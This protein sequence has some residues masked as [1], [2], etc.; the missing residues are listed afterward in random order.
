LKEA[1]LAE[2]LECERRGV[3][4]VYGKRFLK[5]DDSAEKTSVFFENGVW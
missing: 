4:I 5:P 2:S 1:L 3:E